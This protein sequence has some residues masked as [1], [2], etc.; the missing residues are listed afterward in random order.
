MTEVTV[1]RPTQPV[2]AE[3]PTIPSTPAFVDLRTYVNA[4]KT[5]MFALSKW[6][7]PEG[8]HIFLTEPDS[9]QDSD[10]SEDLDDSDESMY[11]SEDDEYSSR[12]GVADDN[13][14]GEELDDDD[15]EDEEEEEEEDGGDAELDDGS[16]DGEYMDEDD[17]SERVSSKPKK[18]SDIGRGKT[19]TDAIYRSSG[20]DKGRSKE[21]GHSTARGHGSSK[22]K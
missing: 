8:I 9:D 18:V 13:D 17:E 4:S 5:P 7:D 11:E 16:D 19:K 3:I 1:P 15:D 20:K 10:I 22:K 12:D 14:D 2:P 6:I 21:L